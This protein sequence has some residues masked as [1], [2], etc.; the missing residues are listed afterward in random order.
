[1]GRAGVL[2]RSRR[3]LRDLVASPSVTALP[4]LWSIQ[5]DL[6]DWVSDSRVRGKRHGIVAHVVDFIKAMG[7]AQPA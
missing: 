6:G 2:C 7:H 1:M 5:E 4:K 3:A